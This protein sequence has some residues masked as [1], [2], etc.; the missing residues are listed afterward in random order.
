MTLIFYWFG[1]LPSNYNMHMIG[2]YNVYTKYK[3]ITF[4]LVMS[5]YIYP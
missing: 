2:T 3:T 4:V 5:G 1:I